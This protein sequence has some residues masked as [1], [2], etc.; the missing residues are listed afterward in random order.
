[1][2]LSFPLLVGH[3]VI[4][5]VTKLGQKL[6]KCKVFLFILT[7]RLGFVY[8]LLDVDIEGFLIAKC[9]FLAHVP[10]IKIVVFFE[11][12]EHLLILVHPS[13]HILHMRR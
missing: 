9:R 7:G 1:M 11:R 2:P 8:A 13:I 4:L 3:T 6:V 5:N 12:S 10:S